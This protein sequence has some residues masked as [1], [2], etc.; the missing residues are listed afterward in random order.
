MRMK[1]DLSQR[2]IKECLE[3]ATRRGEHV[4][5]NSTPKSDWQDDSTN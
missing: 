5:T 1:L 4:L 2:S 3:L